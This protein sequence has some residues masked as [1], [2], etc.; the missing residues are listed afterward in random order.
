MG[1]KRLNHGGNNGTEDAAEAS[2][3]TNN[4]NS[5]T[6]ATTT[7][8]TARVSNAIE[9]NERDPVSVFANLTLQGVVKEN[10]AARIVDCCFCRVHT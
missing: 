5:T 1:R 4:N 9:F 7:T 10:H 3:A 6:A 8:T 2:A